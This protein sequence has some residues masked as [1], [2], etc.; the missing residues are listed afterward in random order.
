MKICAVSP[1]KEAS[2]REILSFLGKATVDLV[3]LPGHAENTPSPQKV[4][5]VIR[6]GI[7]VF[8]EG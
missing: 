2:E 5:R 3:V 8:V 1:W 6:P 4:Q 7:T